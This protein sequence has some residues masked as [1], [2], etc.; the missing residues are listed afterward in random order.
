MLRLS[1]FEQDD[2]R[3]LLATVHQCQRDAQQGCQSGAALQPWNTDSAELGD[4]RYGNTP[5]CVTQDR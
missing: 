1:M 4:R 2:E 3:P 5:V